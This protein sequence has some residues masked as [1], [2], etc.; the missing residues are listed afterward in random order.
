MTPRAVTALDVGYPA[1]GAASISYQRP[2]SM[3]D[4][5]IGR[6]HERA[7][8]EACLAEARAGRGSLV[9]LA[10]EAGVGK[11]TLARRVLAGSGF[12]VLE[13]F[14][15]QAGTSAYGP[16][17]AVLRSHLRSD[18]GGRLIEGPLAAHLA[19][20]LPELGPP[21][22]E[23]DRATLFEAIRLSLAAIAGRH[24][25]A[26]FLDDLHWADDTTLELLPA[27]AHSADEQP[28]LILGAFRSDELPRGHPIRR[29]RSELRRAGHL[30][31]VAVEP[32][33]AEA[34]TTLL[35]RTLGAAAPS[36]RRAVFDRT[37]GVPSSSRSSGRCWPRVGDSSRARPAWSCWKARTSRSLT[38]CGTRSCSARPGCRTTLAARSWRPAAV[39]QTFDPELVADVAELREWPDELLRRGIV[40][41]AEPGRMAFRHALVRDAFYGEIPWTRRAT[42]HRAVAQRLEAERAAPA[43]V[44]EHWVRGRQPD[45][46][47]QSLLAAASGAVH[48]YRDGARALRRALELWPEGHDEHARLDVL[49]R[50]GRWA[51]LAGDHA[52]A[53]GAWREA[54][55][56]RRREG[57]LLRLGEAHRRLAAVFELQGRW[58]EA[59]AAREQA[60][61]AFTRAGSPAD[62]AT[63]RIAAAAHLRSAGSFRAALSL[64][65]TAGQEARLAGRI[66]LEVRVL[67]HEG[68]VRARMGEGHSG[69]ELVQA[70]LALALEHGLTGPAA[71]VYQRLADAFEHVGDSAAAKETYDAAFG[72]CAANALEPTAQLCL[73][74]LAVV[75]RQSG[76]WDHATA[77]CRQVVA[78]PEASVHARAVAT[79]TLGSILGLRGQTRRARPLLLESLTLARRIELVAAELLA[80][81]GLAIADSAEGATGSAAEHCRSILERWGRPRTGITWSRRCA[82][83]RAC[84]P[85]RGTAPARGP[86][87]R[88]W[89]RSLP[90]PARARPCPRCRTRWARRR[91][92]TATPSRRR[93]SSLRRSR[94]STASIPPSSERSRSVAPAQPLP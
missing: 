68:N 20:L 43:V 18:G 74:C 32:L 79:G 73:A 39:G 71:E 56:G 51:E 78:S 86:V 61:A 6:E 49:E 81:W 72:F 7:Q 25:A 55:E 59:L 70:G 50:L 29:L 36:L 14:G 58:Q 52:E 62:A 12:T 27:L 35:E 80:A 76:E 87:P 10:G 38:A 64:L 85:N 16:V 15:I 30:R 22:P 89:P 9:L 57:D 53:V 24:P 92:W 84:S 41:E 31:E 13:G 26:V 63:E 46:A 28:L 54:A 37:D 66:D 11:T 1:G 2:G 40:T 48:A 94:C 4:Q 47:R 65:E 75:L 67:G 17:V 90:P 60:A 3:D 45:R 82:G 88:R 21:G 19:L 34:A 93:S 83:R 8:L 23:G 77:L 5:L 33:D 42:L 69:V 44:A 91:C